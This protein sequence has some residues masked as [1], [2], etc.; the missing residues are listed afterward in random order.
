MI[1]ASLSESKFKMRI[2]NVVR[3]LTDVVIGSKWWD[4]WNT[5]CERSKVDHINLK[6]SKNHP[7]RRKKMTN[8]SH[9]LIS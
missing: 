6:T 3:N 5:V 8:I 4:Y 2:E 9:K 1:P 7:R